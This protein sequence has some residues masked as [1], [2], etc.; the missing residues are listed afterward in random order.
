MTDEIRTDPASSGAD[1]V[2]RL[3]RVRHDVAQLVREWLDAGRFEPSCDAWLRSYDAE[4]T[5]DM[6]ARGLIGLTWPE[7]FGG[8]A[9]PGVARLMVTEELLRYGAPVAA[10]WIADRQIGP[11]ILKHGTDLAR[12]TY[13]PGIVAGEMTF[14]LGMS[15]P[16][17]G[18][19]LASVATKAV[20]SENGWVISG[21]KI[22][23]SQG[24][25]STHAYVLARTSTGESTH[26]GLSEF[27][28][29]MSHPGVTVRP[30]YDL[31]GEHHFNEVFLDEVPVDDDHVIG[32]IGNG[33]DQVTA[34]LALER[35]G[36]ERVLSTYPLLTEAV[37]AA[38]ADP[39]VDAGDLRSVGETL[40]RIATLRAM[41]FDITASIDRGEAP[42]LQAAILKDLGTTL[43]REINEVARQLLDT[44]ADPSAGD[45]AGLLAQGILAAPGFSIR[46]GTTEV[47]RSIIARGVRQ[48]PASGADDLARIVDDV[49]ADAGGEAGDTLDPA[50]DTMRSLG[51]PAVGVDEAHGGEGGSL[52]D[53]VT[54]VTALGRHSVS[55]PVA[56]SILGRRALAAV[57]RSPDP[58][59]EVLTVVLA[60]ADGAPIEL[61]ADGHLQGSA[62]RVPWGGAADELVVVARTASGDRR[63]VRVRADGA[64]LAW[65][66][67]RNLAGEPRDDLTLDHVAA[68]E[69]LGDDAAC[70]Q[71]V[72]EAALFR[73]A[74]VAGAVD[75]ALAHTVQHVTTRHQFG[76]PLIAFQAVGGLLAQLASELAAADVAVARARQAV[77][78]GGP[79]AWTRVAAARV[80]TGRAAT[81]GSR[82]AHQLHAAMGVTREHP[83]H[84]STR[85]A[86]SWRDEF[87]TQRQWAE[88]L[89]RHLSTAGS[90]HVWAWITEQDEG[91]S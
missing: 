28:V 55:A 74:A 77:E 2:D 25:R 78:G 69:V 8:Q 33:W 79:A 63:L 68:G 62:R 82:I 65:T 73:A 58:G 7:E 80:V 14:C 38:G 26:D 43:E 66:S 30:I 61:T 72:A 53:A 18:S 9:L 22:W 27:I 54:I 15:E 51:W 23:T 76:R 86:W 13:L 89:G 21:Q 35:G 24:H 67:G 49:L 56:E 3:S 10:H 31:R 4:F 1:G 64:G 81:E 19:D 50:W 59:T 60:G 70:D 46:G 48:R 32:E 84:L 52:A 91:T 44:E 87:G 75:A 90:D 6:A 57:E 88:R 85:R 37:A 20:R 12:R 34:Q 29:D 83:L 42:V 5:R 41:A 45:G 40:A 47:L 36:I 71:L 11:S 39:A 17:S 16:G